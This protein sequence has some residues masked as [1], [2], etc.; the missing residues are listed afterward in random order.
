LESDE[1]AAVRSGDA[2]SPE[3]GSLPGF[4][5]IPVTWDDGRAFLRKGFGL[6]K[7]RVITPAEVKV[8]CRAGAQRRCSTRA[9]R[10]TS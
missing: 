10:W 8:A 5:G 9:I 1:D 2:V 3:Q 4:A 7:G 6:S